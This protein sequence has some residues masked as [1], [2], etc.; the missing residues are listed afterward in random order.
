MQKHTPLILI[1]VL[2]IS[3]GVLLWSKSSKNSNTQ[4]DTPAEVATESPATR[5]TGSETDPR[6]SVSGTVEQG[7]GSALA[8]VS[9]QLVPIGHRADIDAHDAITRSDREGGWTLSEIPAGEYSL[10]ASAPGFLPAQKTLQIEAGENTSSIVLRLEAGGQSLSGTVR[11]LTGGTITSAILHVV[12]VSA[13]SMDRTHGASA[14]TD[15]EGHYELN[16]PAGGYVVWAMHTDYVPKSDRILITAGAQTLDFGLAPGAVVE[17]DV[18]RLSDN[19]LVP[20]ARVHYATERTSAYDLWANTTGAGSVR[21]DDKGHFRITG[22]NS[23]SLRLSA[24]GDRA[25]TSE[26]THVALGIAEQRDDVEL[27]LVGAY[28]V[29]GRVIDVESKEGIPGIEVVASLDGRGVAAESPSAEDGRFAIDGLT[30]GKYSLTGEGGEYSR[31]MFGDPI[32]VE[33]D[34]DDAVLELTRGAMVHGR[35]EP[36]SVA[37]VGVRLDSLRGVTP[38]SL[39]RVRSEEDGSFTL[40]PLEPGEMQLQAIRPDGVRGETEVTL[41]PSGVHDLLIKM[42]ESGS[43]SGTV[44]DADGNPVGDVSVSLKPDTGER[45][46]SIVVNGQELLESRGHTSPDGS[47]QVTG[48]LAGTYRMRVVD[49]QAQSLRWAEAGRASEAPKS[50]TLAKQEKKSGVQLRV[51]NRNASITGTVLDPDGNPAPDVWVTATAANLGPMGMKMPEGPPPEASEEGEGEER[52]SSRTEMR[53]VVDQSGDGGD[54]PGLDLGRSGEFPPVLTDAEG[55]FR[56]S[57]LREA[58]YDLIAEG[59]RGSARAFVKGVDTDQPVVVKLAALTRIDGSVTIG[60]EPAKNFVVELSG[61]SHRRK[62]VRDDEGRFS[63]HRVDPGRYTVTVRS[64]D[65]ESE[66]EVE[67]IAGKTS[68]IELQMQVLTK[69]RGTLVDESGA[70]MSGTIVTAAPAPKDGNISV[71]V[72]D[73]AKLTGPDGS[74]EV[75]VRPGRYM[76]LAIKPGQGLVARRMLEVAEGED[77]VELGELTGKPGLSLGP[78]GNEDTDE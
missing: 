18:R 2:T 5:V 26:P 59:M 76:L 21:A 43:I 33:S 30:A 34:V 17:G 64:D 70:P 53:M 57:G 65:G 55:K 47:F 16:L 10:S 49:S 52:R 23:G 56:I 12:P 66:S 54:G 15:A 58:K 62:R 50:I 6:S 40:G 69:I 13:G 75:G 27:F 37:E 71:S 4:T 74:F 39:R 51:E 24:R 63:L 78:E 8:G 32:T 28:R 60:N 11:D 31:K 25:A 3:A 44:R 72:G 48:L 7:D 38:G 46:M 77:I 9:V 42:D 68:K 20:G 61:V 36:A 35:V 73:D 29:E 22:L 1:L 45:S 14:Q 41:P 67:V 19:Q